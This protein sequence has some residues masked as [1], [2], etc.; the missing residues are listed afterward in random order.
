[1][2]VLGAGIL[3]C[4]CIIFLI[5]MMANHYQS[6]SGYS[7]PPSDYSPSSR[8]RSLRWAFGLPAHACVTICV[9]RI[10]TNANHCQSNSSR[11][12]PINFCRSSGPWNSVEAGI[13]TPGVGA[14]AG[15]YIVCDSDSYI[16]YLTVTDRDSSHR[17]VKRLFLH[18]AGH[19]HLSRRPSGLWVQLRVRVSFIRILTL[20]SRF[21]PSHAKQFCRSSRPRNSVEA[22]I[23]NPGAG[24]GAGTCIFCD[25]DPYIWYLTITNRDSS[26]YCVKRPFL[27]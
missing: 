25:W 1:M 21:E 24:A 8:L 4:A 16:W 19:R 12:T 5:L 17:C 22:G 7:P 26:H 10:L 23:R 11:V 27:H 18:Q 20:Q 13:W 3:E 9:I 6:R 2:D 15:A 14:G